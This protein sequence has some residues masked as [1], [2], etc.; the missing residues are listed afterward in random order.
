MSWEIIC[1]AVAGLIGVY[2]VG[3]LEFRVREL[4]KRVKG[5]CVSFDPGLNKEQAREAAEA[6]AEYI[7]TVRPR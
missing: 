1:L 6:F 7:K 4:E 5:F 3:R 2:Q